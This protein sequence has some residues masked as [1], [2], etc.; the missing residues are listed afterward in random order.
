LWRHSWP[1][2]AQ[3]EISYQANPASPSRSSAT[4]YLSAW[5][6]SSGWRA[7]SAASGVPADSFA[8]DDLELLD[9]LVE[10][11]ADRARLTRRGRL[12]ANE[13]AVHLR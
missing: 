6:S 11:D 3:F 4:R 13:V 9:G 10:V 1:G 12:L 7:G 8:D 5:S 2:F